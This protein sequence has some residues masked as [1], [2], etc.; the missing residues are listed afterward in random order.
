MAIKALCSAPGAFT[1]K[2][3]SVT[4]MRPLW[5]YGSH[6]MATVFKIIVVVLVVLTV[7]GISTF[8]GLS[9]VCMI[10]AVLIPL[11]LL[12]WL[13]ARIIM[14]PVAKY[15]NG[16]DRF[17][18]PLSTCATLCPHCGSAGPHLIRTGK[19][20]IDKAQMAG[21]YGV[22]YTATDA[23]GRFPL[24]LSSGLGSLRATCRHCGQDAVPGTGT[25]K[26]VPE[27]HIAV[28]GPRSS[29]KSA[30]IYALIQYLTA[31]GK[32]LIDEGV[33]PGGARCMNSCY[34][35]AISGLPLG[36]NIALN[37]MQGAIIT[38]SARATRYCFHEMD[39]T[40][41]N[42]TSRSGS[43]I[44]RVV[45]RIF[46]TV[47]AHSTVDPIEVEHIMSSMAETFE[48][49]GLR[50]DACSLTFVLTNCEGKSLTSKNHDEL[51]GYMIDT[52]GLINVVGYA[53]SSFNK[54]DCI[55]ADI[56]NSACYE[57]IL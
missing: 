16:R 12:F 48:R 38:A 31:S 11:Y 53:R 23:V 39:H 25:I 15:V 44:Y 52:M 6:A 45:K 4:G 26:L 20:T 17:H 34:R 56:L 24:L 42:R 30:F 41:E 57:S 36:R 40:L 29:G 50:M 46:F 3:D 1:E 22:R 8:G 54:V 49:H 28:A 19:Y 51:L 43:E 18:A 7:L 14:W 10:A 13:A 37:T 27:S 35:M 2:F 21:K 32:C 47:N 55:A 33:T 9:L 5:M